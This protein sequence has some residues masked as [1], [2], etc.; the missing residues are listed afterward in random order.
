M[1]GRVLAGLGLA[2][3][4]GGCAG[5]DPSGAEI[6][7]VA[8]GLVKRLFA[9]A[10]PA[11]PSARVLAEITPARLAELEGPLIIAVLEQGD[12]TGALAPA[13]ISATGVETWVSGDGVSLALAGSIVV[14]TRGLADDL[15]A[16]DPAPLAAAA[17]GQ[18]RAQ[19]RRFR[20]LDGEDRLLAETRL[21]AFAPPR[22]ER[23]MLFG[24][25]RDVVHLRETCTG[26]GA[27]I[28]N[29]YWLEP[30]RGVVWKSRQWLGARGGHIVLHRA[31]P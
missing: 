27:A 8:E 1:S 30:A 20:H 7:A 29:D 23:L 11:R 16:A 26:A 28:V 22:P 10:G 14:A 15:M 3:M 6:G 2:L 13:A 18:A 17:R 19:P 12:L 24:T 31:R 9:P 21:C 5:N 25:P 4:L